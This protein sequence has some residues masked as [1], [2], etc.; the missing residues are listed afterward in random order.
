[1]ASILNATRTNPALKDCTPQSV[2]ASAMVAATLKLPIDANLGFSALVPYRNK[3]QMEAQFQIMTKGFVQLAIRTG[4]Y[5]AINVGPVYPGEYHG[6]NPIT[7]EVDIQP[8]AGGIREQGDE[9]QAIGYV[10]YFKLVNGYEKVAY[11]PMDRILAHGKRYSKSFGNEYGMW[12]TNL[13][14]MAAK[15]V[16]KNTL[17]H[18]GILST[19]M[20]MAVKFDQAVAR[21]YSKG[22][23]EIEAA[24]VDSIEGE[25]APPDTRDP[26]DILA[27]QDGLESNAHE[28]KPA[29][30]SSKKLA[31]IQR[32][33]L[34]YGDCD[35]TPETIKGDIEA[36]L[37][38]N[39]EDQ[40]ILGALLAKVRAAVDRK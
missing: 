6:E 32:D 31:D 34:D 4:Q 2:I 14:A 9:S 35:E 21:D 22:P 40:V 30:A 28:P 19:E 15:T 29:R 8:V 25:E 18:W 17:A 36:A 13:P 10:C 23:A 38:A 24:Y 37:K 11:W 20:Q 26:E 33:L 5:Q 12:R 27:P 39:P 3:G 1:L 7:G 16:L